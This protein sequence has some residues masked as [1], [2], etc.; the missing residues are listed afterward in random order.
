MDQTGKHIVIAGGSGFVGTSLAIH[1]RERGY[2][3]TVLSRTPSRPRSGVK[4]A[5]WDGRTTGPWCEVLN[6]A[7]GIVNLAGRSYNC[8]K[9]PDHLDEILRTRIEAT[10][11]LG[12][13]LRQIE[14]PPQVW[15]QFTTAQIVGDPPELLCDESSPDGMGIA[16][17]IG[18]R[19]EEALHEAALPE[20]RKVILR[21]NLVLGKSRGS[22]QGVLGPLELL[23]KLWLGGRAGSGSQGFSWIHEEDL[24]RLVERSLED[25]NMQGAYIAAAPNPVSQAEFMRILRG[26]LG[27]AFGLPA[28]EW[29]VRIGATYLFRS[30]P[31]LVL[32]GRYV[33]SKRL[34]EHGFEF[35]YPHLDGAL[36]EIYEK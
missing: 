23:T 21:P 20:Q 10:T 12:K 9:T 19:W 5:T 1:L 14:Q 7:Y 6:E 13:A 18:K 22:G 29:M 3:V 11:A 31:E 35:R 33:H 30:D 34:A 15:I 32:Y 27:R 17:A 25:P 4:V 28:F 24:N 8:T 2:S 26:V 16:P 36:R